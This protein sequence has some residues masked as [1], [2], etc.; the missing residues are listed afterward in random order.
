MDRALIAMLKA[1]PAE[2][3]IQTEYRVDVQDNL[4]TRKIQTQVNI[5]R[6]I[7]VALIVLVTLACMLTVFE[8]ELAT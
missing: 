6:K 3:A 5:L 8:P 7:A 1:D 4:A 2:K